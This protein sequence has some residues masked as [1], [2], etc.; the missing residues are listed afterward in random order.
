MKKSSAHH[1]TPWP[2]LTPVRAKSPKSDGEY[3]SGAPTVTFSPVALHTLAEHLFRCLR[4]HWIMTL[5]QLL[6]DLWVMEGIHHELP[7]CLDKSCPVL[8]C[9]WQHTWKSCTFMRETKESESIVA[10]VLTSPSLVQRRWLKSL[11]LLVMLTNYFESFYFSL[12]S[13]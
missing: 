12:N 6:M 1:L 10:S 11:R 13:W 5:H 3:E 8:R 2:K 4:R 7:A 9:N